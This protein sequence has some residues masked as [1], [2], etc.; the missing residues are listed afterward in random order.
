MRQFTRKLMKRR[1]KEELINV[2]GSMQ[3]AKKLV[4][5]T[6][7]PNGVRMKATLKNLYLEIVGGKLPRRKKISWAKPSKQRRS[8]FG[9]VRP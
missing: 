4:T 3:E 5:E 2:G 7:L 8:L 6:V 1:L 9:S